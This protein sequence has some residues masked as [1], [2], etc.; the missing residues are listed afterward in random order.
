M[1]VA[2]R[3]TTKRAKTHGTTVFTGRMITPVTNQEEAEGHAVRAMYLYSGMTD[4]A[5]LT[6]DKQYI[7]AIDKI[8]DNM[9]SKKIY[10]QGSIGAVGDGERFGAITNCQ[11][12]L[13]T[14][15]PAPPL[16]MFFGTKGCFYCTAI[17]NISTCWRKPC[18]TA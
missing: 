9:V 18:I 15:K 3:N 17:Q 1:P 12:P 4:V 11:T 5:A 13:L 10:V 16:A 8:W 14:T 2:T 6:G 7:A